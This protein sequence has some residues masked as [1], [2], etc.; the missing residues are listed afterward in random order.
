MRTRTFVSI[1]NHSYKI[2]FFC[3][4]VLCICCQLSVIHGV[5]TKAPTKNNG[6]KTPGKLPPKT[7]EETIASKLEANGST[8]EEQCEC[9]VFYSCR[10]E[11]VV[12]SQR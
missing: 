1:M 12:K 8:P 9:R 11:D 4:F 6:T 10:A 3:V 5:T 2:I 7:G